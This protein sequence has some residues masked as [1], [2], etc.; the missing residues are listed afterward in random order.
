MGIQIG[1]LTYEERVQKGI[2]DS[3]MR[4]AVSRSQYRLKTVRE[5]AQDEL[6]D[7]E[8]WR[9]LGEQ[10]RQHT[11]ENLDYYLEQLSDEVEKRGGK[12]FFAK[13][14]EQ[15]TDYI[16]EVVTKKQ[17]KK[18]VK[19]KS[20]VTEEIGLNDVLVAQGL[21]VVETDLG[22]WIIQLDEDRPSHI[23]APAL[24]KERES[25]RETFAQKR[26]YDGPS[27]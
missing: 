20:M 18:I 16:K 7:W 19:T 11:L 21:E 23:V 17:A 13:T 5:S 26:G 27:E 25:I 22:E 1:D 3:F 6:G 2:D 9:E 4:S 12:V 10:I 8:K 14:A 15:A 24:H